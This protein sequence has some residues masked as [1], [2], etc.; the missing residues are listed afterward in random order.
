Y[1]AD[2]R[3]HGAGTVVATAPPHAAKPTAAK[4]PSTPIM[5]A[6]LSF[7]PILFF[8][9]YIFTAVRSSLSNILISYEP[10]FGRT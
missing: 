5:A 9:S 8:L 10:H 3:G 4:L 7:S 1:A 2:A 6:R